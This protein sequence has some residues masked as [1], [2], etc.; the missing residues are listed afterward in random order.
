MQEQRCSA[1]SEMPALH[2]A[3][4]VASLNAQ[5]RYLS[6][7]RLNLLALLVGAVAGAAALPADA[8]GRVIAAVAAVVLVGALLLTLV[9]QNKSYERTWYGGRAIAESVKTLAWRYMTRAEPFGGD[10]D[11]ETDELFLNRLA[12]ILKSGANLDIHLSAVLGGDQITACMREVRAW[13]LAK[14]RE[15]YDR[16]RI[17]DQRDWYSRK[18]SLSEHAEKRFFSVMWISNLLAV[19][20][21]VVL[22]IWPDLPVN[23]TGVFS[24]SAAAV[25]GWL[26]VKRHQEIAQSY[27]IAAQELAIVHAKV[28][29]MTTEA[30]F[31]LFV[32]DA[33]NAISREHTLW[34][35]RRDAG[36]NMSAH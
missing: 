34:I 2:D 21:A 28:G 6:L 14:R 12:Q 18:S 16:C 3:A 13:P 30:Q 15:Y 31:A 29:M 10:D 32:A 9:I 35:A 23:A 5:R 33:E 8:V 1:P 24:T 17:Q 36:V 25:F 11:A 26:Q 27:A 19:A 7:I 22:V 20:A 4:N